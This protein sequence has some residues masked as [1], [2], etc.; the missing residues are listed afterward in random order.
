MVVV[1]LLRRTGWCGGGGEIWLRRKIEHDE[2]RVV[3]E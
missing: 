3:A 2:E 1:V